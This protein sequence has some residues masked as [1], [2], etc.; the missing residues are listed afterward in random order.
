[1]WYGALS[2]TIILVSFSL[3][4][5]TYNFF[6]DTY[7]DLNEIYAAIVLLLFGFIVPF[8]TKEVHIITS[9]STLALLAR[10]SSNNETISLVAM[11][12]YATAI[13][14]GHLIRER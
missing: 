3:G 8:L 14:S 5:T 6:E 4:L 13:C 11:L 10:L 9:V 12:L 2:L 7:T 1:M